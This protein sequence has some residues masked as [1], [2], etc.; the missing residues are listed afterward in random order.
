MGARSKEIVEQYLQNGSGSPGLSPGRCARRGASWST[1]ERLASTIRSHG[2]FRRLFPFVTHAQFAI[3]T[4]RPYQFNLED[5]WRNL[6]CHA[7]SHP[8][9]CRGEAI[10]FPWCSALAMPIQRSD[11][12]L[13]GDIAI[14]TFPVRGPRIFGYASGLASAVEKSN[15]DIL[16][17][18]SIWMY[19]SVVARRWAGE[20]RPYVVSPHGLLKPWALRNSRWKKRVA[21][22]LYENDASASRR[23]PPRLE[24][25]RSRVIPRVRIEESN[26]RDS[27]WHNV[28]E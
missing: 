2:F 14:R 13:W 11:E 27:E 17:V 4:L 6:R 3:S 15:A 25:C 24:R 18:H 19:P 1:A 10:L 23:L 22:L 12:P 28:A 8:R 26:L 7:Q 20:T 21:A 5:E 16:H 9:D